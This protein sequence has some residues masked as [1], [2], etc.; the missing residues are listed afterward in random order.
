[1]PRPQ[2]KRFNTSYTGYRLP[3]LLQHTSTDNATAWT[4]VHFTRSRQI[5]FFRCTYTVCDCQGY[6]WYSNFIQ[7][8]DALI[9]WVICCLVLLRVGVREHG[10][11]ATMGHFMTFVLR[12]PP[13]NSLLSNIS[14]SKKQRWDGSSLHCESTTALHDEAWQTNRVFISSQSHIFRVEGLWHPITIQSKW[15]TTTTIREK[16]VVGS[17]MQHC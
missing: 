1:M 12:F 14:I 9:F 15:S 6:W 7:L 16:L 3:Y 4:L 10:E 8:H 17:A 2:K 11:H 5:T 13:V